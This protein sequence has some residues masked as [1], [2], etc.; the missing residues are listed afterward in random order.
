MST[1][2]LASN[3]YNVRIRRAE[4]LIA[5]NSSAAEILAFYTHIASFQKNLYL[6]IAQSHSSRSRIQ[7]FGTLRD[8]LDLTIVLPHYRSFLALVETHG[9]SPLA[10]AARELAASPTDGWVERLTAYWRHGGLPEREM[11][12]FEHFF[13]R[14]F[15]EPYALAVAEW[16]A[17][18]P[19]LETPRTCP[20]CGAQPQ[21]GVLR[22][23]GDGGKRYLVCSFC[24]NEWSF[25]RIWCAACGEE[26]EKKLPV[27]VA[28]E[29]PHI[30]VETCETCKCYLRT[31]DLTKDGHAVPVVDDLAAL[32]LTLWAHERGYSRMQPNLLGS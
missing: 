22:P 1:P 15:L 19:A 14:A 5:A 6:K 16:M 13:S 4:T 17:E 21:L 11:S 9:P 18:P 31:I 10:A 20:L 25:R 7:K 29:L 27:Y 12:A 3:V 26:D 32:P 8:A 30:R 23:E 2:Q 28:E 24:G